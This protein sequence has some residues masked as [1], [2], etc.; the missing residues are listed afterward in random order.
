MMSFRD[1]LGFT[2]AGVDE[3]HE[4]LDDADFTPELSEEE[5][6]EEE[7]EEGE[8]TLEAWAAVFADESIMP[9]VDGRLPGGL[10][11]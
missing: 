3:D 7:E 8:A 2:A 11:G 10:D 5:Q 4:E 6:F 1:A 9:M